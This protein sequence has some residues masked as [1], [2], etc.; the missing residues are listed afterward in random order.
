[1]KV[2]LKRIKALEEQGLVRSSRHPEFPL[3]I[4]KY[5][6]IC[7]FDRKWDEYTSMCRGLIVDDDGEVLARPF[8]KFFNIEEHADDERCNLPPLNWNQHFDIMDKLDGSLGIIYTWEGV[9]Y[10]ATAGSFDSDQAIRANQI[11]KSKGYDKYTKY[12]MGVTHL[13]EIIYPENRIVV[14]YE[15]LEDMILLDMVMIDRG[16]FA[17]KDALKSAAAQIGCPVVKFFDANNIQELP[18]REN[19]EG[20]IIRFNDGTRAKMKFEEYK[21]LHYLMTGVTSI[22][23]WENLMAGYGIKDFIENVPDE[24]YNWV[25]E[26][27]ELIQKEHDDLLAEGRKLMEDVDAAIAHLPKER[28]YRALH[29]ETQKR[30][31]NPDVGALSGLIRKN[32]LVDRPDNNFP[33][34]N[35]QVWRM[36]RPKHELPFLLNEES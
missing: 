9:P 20:Y 34:W 32:M 35:E 18:V 26:K 1:M 6:D 13:F 11:F 22:R 27:A 10:V 12:D 30:Q 7:V 4:Y 24:F 15:G 29:E 14:D 23:I 25:K 19:S 36:H 28:K 8:P 2:D 21:R 17:T 16:M 5:T 3:T 31:R 33:H